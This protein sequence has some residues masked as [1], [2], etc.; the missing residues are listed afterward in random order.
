MDKERIWNRHVGGDMKIS[1]LVITHNRL[2]LTRQ[3]IDSLL[4][5]TS[6][7]G[8]DI[9][10]VI[11]DDVSTDGTKEFL[12]EHKDELKLVLNEKRMGVAKNINSAFAASTGDLVI[13]ALGNDALVPK[14]WLQDLLQAKEDLKPWGVPSPIQAMTKIVNV[15]NY[16]MKLRNSKMIYED[17]LN[18]PD[19]VILPDIDYLKK[20]KEVAKYKSVSVV[21]YGKT[22]AF[23]SMRTH[24]CL[25][26]LE[27]EL[28]EKIGGHRSFG[29]TLWGY[30]DLDLTSK[31][32]ASGHPTYMI[33]KPRIIN[34]GFAIDE[35]LY[36]EYYK[37]REAEGQK[38]K[39]IY[40]SSLP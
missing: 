40:L 25:Y 4:K 5:N 16:L 31:L 18:D 32:V 24:N 7:D 14:N 12:I 9:E 34:L 39:Q 3:C 10:L 2:E 23:Q 29:G 8:H 36:N 13:D 28:W 15:E 22:D 38:G 30:D 20:I 19:V 6:A 33:F 17:Y 26:P 37:W 11:A 1:V 27:R 35:I 21:R